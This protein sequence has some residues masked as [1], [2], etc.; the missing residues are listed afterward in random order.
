M[1]KTRW[2]QIAPTVPVSLCPLLK[3]RGRKSGSEESMNN[4]NGFKMTE[5]GQLPEDWEVRKLVDAVSKTKQKDP[6]KNPDWQFKYID[7]SG[8]NRESLTV[9]GYNIYFGKEAPSRAKKLV[10]TGDVIFATVRPTLKRVALIEEDFNGHICSTAFCVLRANGKKVI[11]HFLYFV[12]SREVFIN[13]LGKVQRGASYPAVTDTDVK[14]QKIPLPPLPEQQKIASVLSTIQEAKEKTENVIRETK[15][16]K[17]Y[18]MHTLFTYGPVS[19]EEA[20]KVPL[21]ETEIG[22]IPEHWEVKQL[23]EIA[24]LQR[25]QALPTQNQIL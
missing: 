22:M 4:S 3:N 7:V 10:E 23:G 12:V 5:I 9:E 17:K 2:A 25:G 21:R 16:L 19:V 14:N 8:V 6:A 24:T 11:P 15:E 13:E 20:E 18:M 1:R